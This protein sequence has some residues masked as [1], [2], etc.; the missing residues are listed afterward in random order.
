MRYALSSTKRCRTAAASQLAS[1]GLAM[2]IRA[3]AFG[4]TISLT[5]NQ[6]PIPRTCGVREFPCSNVSFRTDSLA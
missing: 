6:A 4:Q 2:M 3:V 5:S 1:D